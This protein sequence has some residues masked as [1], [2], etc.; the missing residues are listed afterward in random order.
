VPLQLDHCHTRAAP[1]TVAPTVC[2]R[3]L[4]RCRE[5]GTAAFTERMEVVIPL[6]RSG[7][8]RPATSRA[9][10]WSGIGRE[11]LREARS[12]VA[13]STTRAPSL[14]GDGASSHYGGP[15]H[16]RARR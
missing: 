3:L 6:H 5:L 2:A 14:S 11:L 9:H 13:A 8:R 1:P 16:V 4:E 10:N 7:P 12:R 15:R